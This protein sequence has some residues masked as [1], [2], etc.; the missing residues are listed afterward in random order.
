M[1]GFIRDACQDHERRTGKSAQHYKNAIQCA[2]NVL[3][4]LK[5]IDVVPTN[6][7]VP[8]PLPERF[9]DT[10]PILRDAFVNYLNR[11]SGT[12]RPKT[13]TT[14]ATKL[15]HFG[16]FISNLDPMPTSLAQLDRVHHIE[17]FLNSVARATSMTS[18]GP[19]TPADQARRI[20][21]V[22]VFLTEITEWGWADAPARRLIFRSDI[23]RLERPLPRYIPVDQDRRLTQALV[24]SPN[25]LT[26]DALLLAR[27]TG[28]RIGELRDL[29]I[30]CVHDIAGKGSWLKVPL[31]KLDSERMARWT[32]TP[33]KSSIE[34]SPPAR[35][36][37][38]YLT[39]APASR[40]SSCS[41]AM[42]AACQ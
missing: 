21:A 33:S 19:V 23:P 29:Q 1:G 2:H 30:D 5:V 6:G 22:S 36:G 10:H 27:A 25:R 28:L 9:A 41:L 34:S 7:N 35:T 4:H 26:A 12:C 11:K 39:P 37:N 14:M 8:A 3:F 20:R 15:S 42:A 31:G 18:G 13:I 16:R 38:P 24:E 40:F 17:P 32:P